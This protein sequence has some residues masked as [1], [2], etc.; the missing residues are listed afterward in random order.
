MEESWTREVEV[1]GE[2]F[3]L[4]FYRRPFRE[5]LEVR[6]TVRGTEISLAE[7]GLGELA[8]LERAKTR[9][10]EELRSSRQ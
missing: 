9:I 2:R 1:C 5:G 8:L 3:E 6:V 7:L 4:R 10:E